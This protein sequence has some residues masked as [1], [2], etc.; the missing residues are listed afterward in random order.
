MAKSKKETK[1]LKPGLDQAL[2]KIEKMFGKGAIMKF[3]KKSKIK[4]DSIS[5]G[6]LE[7]DLALGGGGLPCGRTTELF[8]QEASGKTTLALSIIRETQKNKGKVAYIDVE[9]ALDC[10][11]A[12]KTGVKLEDLLLSQPD[13]GEQALE[14]VQA[15]VESGEIALIVI[16]SVAALT[17]QAEIDGSM[18][19]SVTGDT[20]L[21]IKHKKELDIVPIEDLYR[22]SWQFHGKRYT[23][24]YKK[25]KSYE[26]YT[27]DGWS[28][29]NAIFL[30]RVKKSKKLHLI[31]TNTGICKV[32]SDHSLFIKNKEIKTEDLKVD[33]E[34]DINYLN[35]KNN[36]ANSTT[37]SIA[38]LLGFFCAE[39]TLSGKR[40]YLPNTDINLIYKSQKILEK[41]LGVETHI[42]SS[43]NDRWK[44]NCVRKILYILKTKSYKRLLNLFASCYTKKNNYKKVPSYHVTKKQKI[45][46]W[47]D[48][49][50]A[51]EEG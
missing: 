22:G 44:D 29:I 34:L 43:K 35:E 40:I 39:G 18:S 11:Y 45:I 20:P 19:D 36:S 21:F 10:E 50:Q 13:S 24:R 46:V 42:Y 38:W 17:P 7:L 3:D 9:H 23:N 33:Q 5:T 47:E 48:Y 30:K 49:K 31:K 16:D 25:L 28:K 2:A 15:L 12:V 6:S 51:L 37:K 14:I 41:D 32:S 4:T 8:G 27:R 26:V 1:K